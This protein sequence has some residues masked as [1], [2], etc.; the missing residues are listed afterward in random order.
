MNTLSLKET[1]IVGKN[2]FIIDSKPCSFC[3]FKKTDKKLKSP[4]ALKIYII[5]IAKVP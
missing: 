5:A 4:V 1:S 2:L 3:C